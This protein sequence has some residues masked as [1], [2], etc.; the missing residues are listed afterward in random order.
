M[1]I[2]LQ[3]VTVHLEQWGKEKK[4]RPPRVLISC[5]LGKD[6][7]G[8]LS[9]LCQHMVGASDEDIINEYA[10]SHCIREV[11]MEKVKNY[12]DGKVDLS[13]YAD[14]DPQTMKKTLS[15][16]REKYG[17]IDDY[18]DAIGFSASWRQRFVNV[19]K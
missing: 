13:C 14:C 19:A 6:R 10:Q 1:V 15:Y 7:T 9:M 18:L 5:T 11:A 12:L 17:S 2:A 3:A 8:N 4:G 16:L